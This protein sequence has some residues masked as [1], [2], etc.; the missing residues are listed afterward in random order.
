MKSKDERPYPSYKFFFRELNY[1]LKDDEKHQVYGSQYD[2]LMNV[3]KFIIY[4]I[5][6]NTQTDSPSPL[7]RSCECASY[8]FVN[9]GI[10]I[11]ID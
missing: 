9:L 1:E 2:I 11:L 7:G 10:V 4:A 3:P 8:C 6:F 5:I